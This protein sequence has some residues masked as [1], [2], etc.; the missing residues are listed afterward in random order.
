MSILSTHDPTAG[1][2]RLGVTR[3]SRGSANRVRPFVARLVS[4]RA[5]E[6]ARFLDWAAARHEHPPSGRR[7]RLRPQV[8]WAPLRTDAA[9]TVP[10]RALGG[11]R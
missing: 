2:G 11:V 7:W 6:E 3:R 1:F 10:F 5:L 4:Q 8:V 9:P